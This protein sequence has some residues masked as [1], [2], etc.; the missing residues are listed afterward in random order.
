MQYE[1][2]YPVN[3]LLVAFP[4]GIRTGMMIPVGSA[5]ILQVMEHPGEP[6]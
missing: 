3:L 2:M 5:T 6:G 4:S 1:N